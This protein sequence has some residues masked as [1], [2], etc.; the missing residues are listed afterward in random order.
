MGALTCAAAKD[1]TLLEH[2]DGARPRSSRFRDVPARFQL[3]HA[4]GASGRPTAS[5]VQA[6]GPGPM[7]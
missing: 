5:P 1:V 7:G 6:V 4:I 3:R 2:S